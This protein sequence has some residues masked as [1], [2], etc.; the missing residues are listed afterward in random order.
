MELLRGLLADLRAS[1]ELAW[2]LAVRDLRVQY[3]QSYLGYLW[4]FISPLANTAAWMFLNASGVIKVAD[5]GIPYPAYVFS[6][7][8]L[9]QLLVESFQS[10]LQQLGAA[11]GMLAKLNFPREAIIMSGFIKLLSSAGI[12]LVILLPA[13]LLL[14]VTPDW[15]LVLVPFAMLL[16]VITGIALGLL[17]A[18]LGML[19]TDIGRAIP[20]AAQFAMY[21]T[22][23]VFAMPAQGRMARIL[24]LN[25]ATPLILTARAWLTGA[26]SPMLGY[27]IGVCTTMLVLLFLGLLLY[28]ITMPLL[29]ERLNS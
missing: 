22:P 9:W 8:M 6:G 25:P 27:F 26:E 18:P 2:R 4:A 15:H 12:K 21:I 3:R 16:L 14:G 7:T 19:Y 23:V 29:I 17:V 5:T 1:R 20:L 10:P 11:K 24:E 13:L 28:R